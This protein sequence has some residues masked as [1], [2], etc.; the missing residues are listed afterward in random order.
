MA[1]ILVTRSVAL[2]PTLA[3]A[4]LMTPD[5]TQLDRMNQVGGGH[6]GCCAVVDVVVMV[7]RWVV[8]GGVD[9]GGG[10]WWVVMTR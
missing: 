4:L 1:R 9:G 5:S 8:G 10:W 6:P 7:G 2:V 3:V